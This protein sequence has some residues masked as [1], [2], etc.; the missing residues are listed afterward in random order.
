MKATN[1]YF[2]VWPYT[3]IDEASVKYKHYYLYPKIKENGNK[4]WKSTL[5][6]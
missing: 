5:Q 1:L 3:I 2:L 6:C 4:V